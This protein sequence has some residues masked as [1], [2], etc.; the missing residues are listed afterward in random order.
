MPKKVHPQA[1]LLA[2]LLA[3]LGVRAAPDE[4]LLGQ[5]AGYP[6][7]RNLAQAYREPYMVGSFSAMD[8]L[9]PS[10][11]LAPATQPVP[12]P[13][14]ATETDFRYRFAGRSWALDDYLQHQR[15]TA[16]LVLKDGAIMAERYSYGRDAGMRMLSNSMAKTVVALA[17]G[18]ALEEGLIR[19]LNDSAATYAPALAGTLYGDTRIVH[20][21]RMASGA[22]YVEDYTPS[23]DRARFN[24]AVRRV[25][26]AQAARTIAERADPEGQRFNYAG[27]QTDMLGLVLRGAT[28]RS[29]C[30]YVAEKI[31]Q[32]LGAET[33]AKWLLNPA[34]GLELAAGGFN[35][36]V[37]D[38]A[39][40][41]WMLANDGQAQGRAVLPR[42]YLL[43][44]TEAARQPEA[45]R[46]GRMQNKGSS[47]FGYGFQVWLV[48]GSHRRFVLLG[49]HGQAILVDPDLKLVVV[50]TAVGKDAAGDASGSHL[51]AERDALFRGIV[52]HY[53]AW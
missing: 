30:D 2:V 47:Y 4:D 17:I 23:D 19:S 25:G 8:G 15:A 34:D 11:T 29:L 16:L 42:D 24:A 5:A 31:W 37:R 26:T 27:A 46:P 9:H 51:G 18:K 1:L 39:R 12:L 13:Q 44:M 28:G 20:L 35:A 43:D 33:S 14:A 48:P 10:C 40:L 32:P 38:Y 21:L 6:A 22:R 36:T 41:G 50:H 45:F 3:S 53:G 7:G 52:A 49:I